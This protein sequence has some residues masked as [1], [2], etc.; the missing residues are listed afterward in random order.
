MPVMA[1]LLRWRESHDAVFGV[2]VIVAVDGKLDQ[3]RPKHVG[4][5]LQHDRDQAQHH[6]ASVRPQVREQAAHQPAVVC[7]AEYVFL[8][9]LRPRAFPV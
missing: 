1:L 3:V 9:G 6:V 8:S 2:C 5:R 7:L 4:T